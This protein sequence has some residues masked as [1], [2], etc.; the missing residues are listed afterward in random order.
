MYSISTRDPMFDSGFAVVDSEVGNGPRVFDPSIRLEKN[1]GGSFEFSV[2]DDHADLYKNL[3][4]INDRILVTNNGER[5]F[6]GRPI[7]ESYDWYNRR[8]VVCEG[9][10]AFLSDVVIPYVS[11]FENALEYLNYLIE[12]YNNSKNKDPRYY[13]STVFMIVSVPEEETVKS[14]ADLTS[15]G[16]RYKTV[17][18]LLTELLDFLEWDVQVLYDQA[19][20]DIFGL[21]FQNE[22]SYT[23]PIPVK[24]ADNLLDITKENDMADF[25]TVFYPLGRPKNENAS[26]LTIDDHRG[27]EL[28]SECTFDKYT[29]IKSDGSVVTSHYLREDNAVVCYT[30]A[31]EYLS[32]GRTLFI[33]ATT[34]PG[35]GFYTL[36]DRSGNPLAYEACPVSVPDT[37]IQRNFTVNIPNGAY[38]L[39]VSKVPRLISEGDAYTADGAWVYDSEYSSTNLR[40]LLSYEQDLVMPQTF[41]YIDSNGVVIKDIDDEKYKVVEIPFEDI[42]EGEKVIITTKCREGYGMYAFK[43]DFNHTLAIKM[44]DNTPVLTYMKDEV[45]DIPEGATH[46]YIGYYGLEDEARVYAYMEISDGDELTHLGEDLLVKQVSGVRT[47]FGHIDGTD[48]HIVDYSSESVVGAKSD[49]VVYMGI[50]VEAGHKYIYSGMNRLGHGMIRVRG[51]SERVAAYL[52]TADSSENLTN[53]QMFEFE[54]PEDSESFSSMICDLGGII[55]NARTHLWEYV[56]NNDD[57][58]SNYITIES[59]NSGYPYLVDND[60]INQYG[61]IEKV[62]TFEDIESPKVLLEKALKYFSDIKKKVDYTYTAKTLDPSIISDYPTYLPGDLV[63]VESTPHKVNVTMEVKSSELHLDAP[64]NNVYEL[65]YERK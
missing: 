21:A 28:T 56:D 5:I 55:G 35:H 18:E 37:P 9:A 17:F 47:I 43:D 8:H 53:L 2:F 57:K 49:S 41:T 52:K 22:P 33:I 3:K 12:F 25:A 26:V 38:A 30:G 46:L 13:D 39:Y 23:H 7:Q 20:S 50:S 51:E 42:I 44:S 36:V 48:G 27:P 24:F 16:D 62:H 34:I 40:N 6:C 29:V 58:K 15:N 31:F 61:W 54:V 63:L 10:L 4:L 32:T 14:V 1:R 59:E 65:V 60:L 19:D 11:S 45:I 64:Q